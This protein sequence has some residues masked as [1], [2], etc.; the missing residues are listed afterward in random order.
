MTVLLTNGTVFVDDDLRAQA[1]DLVARAHEQGA[2]RL[3]LVRDGDAE[4]ALSPDLSE[5]LIQVLTGLARGPVSVSALP[6][7][8]TTTVA[9]ELI[10]VSRPTL[11]KMVRDGVLPA[12]QVG[13]HTRLRTEDVLA[14]RK[15]RA[16]ERREAF[17]ALLR[18][19]E[20]FGAD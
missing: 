9:A 7:E 15:T 5:L 20:Q 2:H 12:H 4:A 10:G 18:L 3:A 16:R 13:S 1:A 19:D 14:L 6:E 11:M 17:E 8:L